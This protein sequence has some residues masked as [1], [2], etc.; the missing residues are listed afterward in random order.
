MI[1][2]KGNLINPSLVEAVKYQTYYAHVYEVAYGNGTPS[3]YIFFKERSSPL[4]FECSQQEFDHL[5]LL[6]LSKP[7]DA[8]HE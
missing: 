5:K 6:L 3:A 2:W 8:D 7:E 1:E 4:I